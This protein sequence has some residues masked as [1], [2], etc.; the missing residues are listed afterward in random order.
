MHQP[1]RRVDDDL[2]HP[3]FQMRMVVLIRLRR[4]PHLG[5]QMTEHHYLDDR[6]IHLDE[7]HLVHR[8]NLVDVN[9]DLQVDV[10][11]N[12]GEQNLDVLLPY[13]DVVHLVQDVLLDEVD[14]VQVDVALVDVA[15]LRPLRMD[16]Y[17]HAVD[18]EDS[19]QQLD[20]QQ[21][22]SLHP[23]LEL[24]GLEDVAQQVLGQLAQ[25]DLLEFLIGYELSHRAAR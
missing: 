18:V 6:E 5:H 9:L 7:L 17:Q 24:M 16:C 10:L 13:L 11:Q 8:L 14:V 19:L 23:T 15:S 21:L 1:Y 25:I 3:Y 12:L 20:L 22:V 4:L 2:R